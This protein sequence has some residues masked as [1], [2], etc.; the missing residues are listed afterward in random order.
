MFVTLR[1]GALHARVPVVSLLVSHGRGFAVKM[2]IPLSRFVVDGNSA[3]LSAATL[4]APIQKAKVQ[5]TFV[6][7]TGSELDRYYIKASSSSTFPYSQDSLPVLSTSRKLA[8]VAFVGRSNV[9][10]SS[11]INALL[12]AKLAATSQT[13]G[14]TK[15]LHFFP[16]KING[17]ASHLSHPAYLVRLTHYSV[18]HGAHGLPSAIYAFVSLSGRALSESCE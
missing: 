1:L 7:C 13:P 15:H 8:E 2:R 18:V 10:K 14:H 17:K 5:N 6:A 16:L 11:L 9:G 4:L 12:Q 3:S